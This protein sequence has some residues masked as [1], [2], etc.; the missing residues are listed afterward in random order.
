MREA[1]RAEKRARILEGA[2]RVFASKGFL[3]ATV[4]EVAREAGVADG[5]IYLYFRSKDD[6]LLR[7]VEARMQA[8]RAAM[9]EELARY[10]DP[11]DKLA[12]FIRF[13]LRMVE[14]SPLE[15]QVL[16]VEL[17]QS[18]ADLQRALGELMRPYLALLGG[19]IEEG[20]ACGAMRPLDPRAVRHAIVGALDEVALS[21]LL[22]G[23][24][25][26]LA[27]NAEHLA[28]LFVRGLDN[29]PPRSPR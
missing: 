21:W 3:T 23:R 14:Q 29:Q 5:T 28:D 19:V 27:R 17:R 4:A 1:G 18:G 24:R 8:L 2:A 13:H 10:E 12:A 20:I 25:F 7:L 16:I 9:E 11:R 6:L 22:R 26:D 15:A